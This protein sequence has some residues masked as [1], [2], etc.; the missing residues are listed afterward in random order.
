MCDRLS[1]RIPCVTDRMRGLRVW[2]LKKKKKRRR[3]K[4]YNENNKLRYT[5][6]LTTCHPRRIYLYFWR[7]DSVKRGVYHAAVC[8]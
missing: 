5:G 3:K 7:V 2:P 4:T 8:T 1:E 6:S